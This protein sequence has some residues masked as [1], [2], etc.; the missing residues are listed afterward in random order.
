VD[1]IEKS[2]SFTILERRIRLILGRSEAT[3]ATIAGG[4]DRVE[5]G[6]LT[7]DVDSRRAYWRGRLVGLTIGE[8]ALVQA[9][10]SKAG[11]DVGYRELY[12]AGRGK[13]F[14][15]GVGDD[16]YRTNVRATIKR[17]REKFKALDPDF[18]R[19]GNYPGF[20]YLWQVDHDVDG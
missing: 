4:G 3:Q 19:I 1:F 16:G 18:E 12:D 8:F 9:L 15:A 13:G 11:R 17:I 14:H 20:G 7:L 2:R 6:E 5:T 10:A